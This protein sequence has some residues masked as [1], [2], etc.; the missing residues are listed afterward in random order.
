MPKFLDDIIAV[1]S[2]KVGIGTTSPNGVLDIH[3]SL[4]N[5]RV[6]D[7]GGMYFRNSSNATHESYIHPRSDGSLSIGRVAESNW[8]GSGT[9]AFASTTYD[10]LTFDTSSNA[11]FAGSVISTDGTDTATLSKTGLVLSRSNS[12]IQSNADNSDTL[13]IGQSSVRWGNVKVDGATFKVLNGG[14][15]RLG[16]SS[17]GNATFA[18]SV[19]IQSD[20]NDRFLVRSNDYTISRIISRGS[21]GADLDK[22]LFSLMSS[23]G[24]NNNV[25][26]V[27]IDSAS[28]SWFNGGN[29]GIGTSS[30]GYPLDVVSNSSGN[31]AKFRVRSTNDFGNINFSSYD[32]TETLGSI[33]FDRTGTSIGNLR[34]YT[35]N[36]A[37]TEK[38]RLTSDGRLGIGTSS[39][40]KK[41]EVVGSILIEGSSDSRLYLGSNIAQTFSFGTV[42]DGSYDSMFLE[43]SA[44]AT[45]VLSVRGNGNIGIGTSSATRKFVV[46]NAGA[47]GI[48]IEPNYS[49]GVNEILSYNRSTSAYE[50]MRFNGTDFEFQSSGTQ[51]FKIDSSGNTTI[52][53]TVTA[54]TTFIADAVDPGNPSAAADNVRVSGYG[55][56]GN[57]GTVYLTNASTASTANIQIGVGG[58]HAAATKLTIGADGNATFAGNVYAD[59]GFLTGQTSQYSPTGGGDTLATFTG[60]GNDRQD[61]VVSNQTNHASAAA[62]L[63][64]ATH[65]HDF[66]IKG[67]SSAGGSILSLGYN[68]TPFLS[69]TNTTAT[70]AGDVILS[71]AQKLYLDGGSNSYIHQSASDVIDVVT[72]GS[73]RLTV[74]SNGISSSLSVYSGGS[75]DFRNY[76]GTWRGTT[77]QTGNGFEFINSADGT[78]L[79]ISSTGDITGTASQTGTTSVS[80]PRMGR[81]LLAHSTESNNVVIH[82]YFFNDLANFR[83][84]GGTITYG[85]L[86]SNPSDAAS[87]I[88]FQASAL[89][90]SINNNVITG[91]TW[92][93]EL[94]DFPRDFYYGTRFGISF[95]SVS[96]APSSMLIQYSSDNGVNYTTALTSS[97]RSE[98]YHTYISNGGT[99][100]NAVKFTIGKFNTYSPRVMNIYAYNYDSRGMTEYFLDKAGGTLYG[101]L[102]MNSAGFTLDGNTI[103]GIDNDSEHTA[104]D[105][106]IMTSLAIQNKIADNDNNFITASALPTDFVS[107]ANG[108]TFAGALTHVRT[109][110]TVTESA[111]SGAATASALLTTNYTYTGT[112]GNGAYA[113]QDYLNLAGSGG[114]FQNVAGY[115]MMT[116]VTSTG[117]STALK[118]IISRVHTSSAGDIN[119]VANYVT[120]N[121]FAGSGNVGNW[122][123]LAIADLGGGF[124]NTQTVTNTYGIKIGDITHGTQTNAPYAIH[125]GSERVHFGGNLNVDGNIT[126]NGNINGDGSTNV[127]NMNNVTAVKLLANGLSLKIGDQQGASITIGK[128]ESEVGG[129]GQNDATDVVIASNLTVTK[130]LLIQGELE[131]ESTTN[132]VIKDNVIQLNDGGSSANTKDSGIVIHRGTSQNVAIVWDEDGQTAGGAFRFIATGDTASSTDVSMTPQNENG[133]NV[134]GGASALGFQDV[135]A[136][137]FRAVGAGNTSGFV[138]DGSGVTNLNMGNASS[139]TLAAARGGTGLS[140]ISTLLNSNVTSVSGSSGSCTGNAATATAFSTTL[141]LTTVS[142][143]FQLAA[144]T[145]TDTG[146]DGTDLATGTYAM[147]VYVD[148]HYA[149]GGHFDEYYSATISWYSGS[150][151]STNHDEIVLHRAGH[152]SNASHL[153]IRTLRAV[154]ADSHDLMLQ[155]KQNFAHSLALNG[156]DGKTMTFKFRRLI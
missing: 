133:E 61:I 45:K 94:K 104:N 25:E 102:T 100:I 65:G 127:G 16:I 91:S 14:T 78:A 60:S 107:A 31:S 128:V 109:Q 137:H 18:G 26:K 145:W 58:T 79:T 148:D 39:P 84:R 3:A 11:T 70:F 87:D 63:V 54:A 147:Q 7:Y 62:S 110:G 46:S 17:S 130:K 50:I 125:T 119:N 43:Y 136:A 4:G 138:G 105:N 88:M 40:S 2:S 28:N 92:T 48:E 114:S 47:S 85:G 89:T 34:F 9:G 106:H 13:N 108:G 150:T 152:A 113:R 98:Y 30:P 64:L 52:A 123:G 90:C 59:G 121:E 111:L 19:S 73:T 68:T 36:T 143:T 51:K 35:S 142:M 134:I 29:V 155:V 131:T 118:N 139:G 80:Q 103:T 132:T 55:V 37:N 135:Y 41:L 72:G 81:Q 97:V 146:I 22:G 24:T 154:N 129:V 99:A 77:G 21:S 76:S 74:N 144:N 116:T 27:R 23:D 83:K 95:G 56:M 101:N 156:T 57:R 10:H 140:S 115:Q 124:E 1:G 86:S 49:S 8:T 122:A 32:G 71:A 117:T 66:I 141:G 15:E 149:G 69:L 82:P 6:N 112:N 20:N 126:A 75:G 12:Y 42:W 151:N 153:Q 67:T 53:G 5:W 93:I 33:Y 38:M 120:H 96:F 44:T